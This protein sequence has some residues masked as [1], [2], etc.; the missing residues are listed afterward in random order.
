MEDHLKKK[1]LLILDLERQIKLHEHKAKKNS[2]LNSKFFQSCDRLS[3]P[4]LEINPNF[5]DPTH[6]IK[7]NKKG[8]YHQIVVPKGTAP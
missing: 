6:A 1:S 7:L 8:R 4:S 2:H 3:V 5:S